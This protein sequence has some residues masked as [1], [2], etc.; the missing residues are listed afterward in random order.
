[1]VGCGL[2][3]LGIAWLGSLLSFG[4]RLL[5]ARLFLWATFL[6]FPLGFIATLTGW[7]TAEVGRQPWV[8]YNQ[9]RTAD[10]VTPF[11][12]NPQVATSL[13]IFATIYTLIFGFGVYYIYRQ[14]QA[15]P[16][17]APDLP[18]QGTNPK[19]PLSIAGSSPGVPD[20]I[21]AGE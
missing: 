21:Q 13:A 12:T 9:L 2:L 19:R 8:V 11:L 17:P 3:M 10:A 7:F 15:G 6:S 5:R 20:A 18:T 14:L 16:I 4:E 1:M